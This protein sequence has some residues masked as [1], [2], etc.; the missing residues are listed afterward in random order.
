MRIMV[1]L[2]WSG[3]ILADGEPDQFPEPEYEIVDADSGRTLVADGLTTY[4]SVEARIARDFSSVPRWRPE[5]ATP[6]ES[7]KMERML[8]LIEDPERLAQLDPATAAP[9]VDRQRLSVQPPRRRCTR[10]WSLRSR[11][12]LRLTGVVR[13]LILS[14]SRRAIPR[15]TGWPSAPGARLERNRADPDGRAGRNIERSRSG[16]GNGAM[17]AVDVH[18]GDPHTPSARKNAPATRW[19]DRK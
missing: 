9:G 3:G 14:A 15:S 7:L 5:P 8:A 6:E 10:A 2:T 11:A 19:L 17:R 1:E 12:S 13:A 4:E 18:G 16:P